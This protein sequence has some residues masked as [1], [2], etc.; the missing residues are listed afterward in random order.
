LAADYC[1]RNKGTYYYVFPTRRWAQRAIWETTARIGGES[2]LVIDH[3][4]PKGIVK[5]KVQ[6]DL[7]IETIN[8]SL[9]FMGGSDNLDFVGQGG[10]GYTLSEFSLHKA[11]VT[12]LLA[13]IIEQSQA[14]IHM[15]GTLRGKNNPLWEI[16]QKTEGFPD[17]YS[18]WMKPHQ[19]K[20]YCW[21]GGDMNVN[22][23]IMELIGKKDPRTGRLYENVQGVP[24][25]NIQN[26]IDSGLVSN[27]YARQEFLNDVVSHVVGGYYGYEIA[28]MEKRGSICRIDP[29]DDVVYT[30]WDLGGAREDSDKT[31]ILFAHVDMVGKTAKIVDYYENT[32][33]KRGHYFDVLTQ[34]GYRYGGHWFPH[35]AKRSNEWTGETTA[36]TA[37][38]EFGIEVRFI[39]KTQ[40]VLNDIEITRRGF[41]GL[42]YDSERCGKLLEHVGNYH[43]KE[44]TGKPCHSN[45][46]TECH[47]ASHGADTLRGLCMAMHL[48]LVTPYLMGNERQY[49]PWGMDVEYD[50]DEQFLT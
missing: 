47:G 30:F 29:F 41:T 40:N 43:E 11:A 27:A 14:Y 17:W 8:G 37:Y 31:A 26:M 3:V 1:I 48:G 42:S 2:K 34:K 18:R 23:E 22:P 36:D 20:L 16:M 45:N 28:A 38:R 39:P 35:D 44:T 12:S 32:G 21:V 46:C 50:M 9:F 7:M 13:P 49:V 4:F 33:R 19:S 15:N 25:Y 5:R 10:Q 6:S 24:Y